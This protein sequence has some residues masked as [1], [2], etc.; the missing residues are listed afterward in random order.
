ME[1]RVKEVISKYA[2]EISLCYGKLTFVI[3]EG[4]VLDV[5]IENRIRLNK[6]K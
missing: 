2:K 5:I 4:E 1:S 3:Q 6:T